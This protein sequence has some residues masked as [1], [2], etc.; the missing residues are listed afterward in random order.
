MAPV[1]SVFGLEL[2]S[3]LLAALLAALTSAALSWAA[4]GKLGWTPV[5]CALTLLAMCAA[6]LI[7]ARLWNAAVSPGAYGPDRPWYRLQLS[8]LSFYGGLLGA[9]PV[10]LAAA[11]R[12]GKDLWAALDAFTLPAAAAF[13]IA[14]AG[15]FL[16]GCCGGIATR[17]PWGVVF[18]SPLSETALRALGLAAFR[19]PVHPTQLYE[20][21]GAALG[22]PLALWAVRRFSFPG[23]GRFL[24]YGIWFTA[25]RLGVLPLRALSYPAWVRWALYPALY[26]ALIAA[27]IF[28]L[29]RLS[30]APSGGG[31]GDA[32]ASNRT[33]DHP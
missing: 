14:R 29:R 31:R 5:S 32:R 22:I 8:G 13:C 25:V 3:Y 27:G 33:N 7:G 18:P 30:A 26:L 15:C 1:L 11:R 6:F 17:L 9:F 4:L 24:V 10:L 21:L 19:T 20:L 23:G 16:N 28:F 2:H 12:T